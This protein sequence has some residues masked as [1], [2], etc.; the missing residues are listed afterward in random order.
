MLRSVHYNGFLDIVYEPD[1]AQGED[2]KT[3]LPRVVG[4]LRRQLRDD[5]STAATAP[6]QPGADRYAAVEN[7]RVSARPRGRDRDRGGVPRRA[8]RRSLGCRLLQQHRGL[9]RS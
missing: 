1:K 3:A 7:G 5:R 9:R 4:F 2:I 8:D 6:D